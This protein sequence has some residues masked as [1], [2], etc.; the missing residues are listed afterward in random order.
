MM[1]DEDREKIR[2]IM[3]DVSV[4]HNLFMHKAE[5]CRYFL[6]FL[7]NLYHQDIPSDTLNEVIDKELEQWLKRV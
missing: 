2:E 6:E 1:N 3:E 4:I 5:H 7:Q